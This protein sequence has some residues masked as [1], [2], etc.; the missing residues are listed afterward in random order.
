MMPPKEKSTKTLQR[1]REEGVS[2]GV[3]EGTLILPYILPDLGH[4]FRVQILDFN[5]FWGFRKMNIFRV[6]GGGGG[7]LAGWGMMNRGYI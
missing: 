4:F 7:G 6:G 1:E 5:I 3:G 2:P